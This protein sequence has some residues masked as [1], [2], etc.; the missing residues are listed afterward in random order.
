MIEA[1]HHKSPLQLRAE[2]ACQRFRSN[3]RRPVVIEFAGSPKAG[4]SSTITQLYTFLKR[5]GFKVKIVVERASICPVR[6]KKHATFNIWTACTTLAQILENTQDPPQEDD[7]DILI[8]DR[9]LFDAICWLTMMDRL[10]RLTTVAR[11]AVEDFLLIEEWRSRITGVF[12]MVASPEEALHR[13]HGYLPVV[14]DGSIMNMEVLKQILN[15]TEQCV[16]RFKNKFR[17]FR[18]DTSLGETKNPKR[19]AELVAETALGWIEEHLEEKILSI[20]KK[21]IEPLFCNRS[22]LVGSDAEQVV[23]ICLQHGVFGPREDVEKDDNSVQPIPVVI[24]RNKSGAILQLKRRE[25]DTNNPLHEKMVIWAGGHVRREDAINGNSIVHAVWRELNE[26]LRLNIETE[27]LKFLGCVYVDIGKASK[28]SRHLAIVY[29]WYAAT[30]DVAITLSTAE[31]FERRGTSLSGRF[32]TAKEIAEQVAQGME[33][34]P[35]N[36]EILRQLLR[37]DLQK[38]HLF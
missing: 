22:T 30:D 5:C 4:K 1:Q 8:L 31:F 26:E 27:E 19:T 20:D 14:G 12:V 18:I 34:E 15:T 11:E 32:V 17:L 16:E 36:N 29:E 35:W 21:R 28:T 7:P 2:A 23:T 3:A 10:S 33:L 9:G 25:R 13:E 6:D 24:V 37:M 38:T